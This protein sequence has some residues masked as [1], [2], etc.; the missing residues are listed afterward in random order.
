[1]RTLTQ[2]ELEIIEEALEVKIEINEFN[3]ATLRA[4]IQNDSSEMGE[5]KEHLAQ[6]IIQMEEEKKVAERLLAF[7]IRPK[8]EEG[9]K[10]D[11]PH[12]ER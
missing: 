9:Q 8:L 1:M 2:E 6:D 3:I 11:K 12:W 5:L 10:E 4:L 7:V